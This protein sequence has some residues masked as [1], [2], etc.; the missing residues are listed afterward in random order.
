M[1]GTGGAGLALAG[2]AIL[3]PVAWTFVGLVYVAWQYTVNQIITTTIC[4]DFE[5]PR[6]TLALLNFAHVASTF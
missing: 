6:Y 3:G 5:H 2:S 1:V 4:E